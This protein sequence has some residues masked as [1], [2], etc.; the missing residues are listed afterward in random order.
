ML[1]CT[2][3]QKRR[4]G[5]PYC[6]TCRKFME[7]TVRWYCETYQRHPAAEKELFLEGAPGP[8]LDLGSLA[9]LALTWGEDVRCSRAAGP[10]PVQEPGA[11]LRVQGVQLDAALLRALPAVRT[12]PARV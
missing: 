4:K 6:G 5:V 3:R 10:V 8:G 12:Q 7:E 2:T 11:R 9:P 1:L